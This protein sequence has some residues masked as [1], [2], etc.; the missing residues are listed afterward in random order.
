MPEKDEWVMD[1]ALV[2]ERARER[3]C[4]Y[5]GAD[6]KEFDCGD[7]E[8]DGKEAHQVVD[9]M[10]CDRS[11]TEVYFFGRVI[12]TDYLEDDFSVDL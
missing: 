8:I 2:T 3:K 6:R 5:C 10:A 7:V 9:C 1:R 4:P 11:F 12:L